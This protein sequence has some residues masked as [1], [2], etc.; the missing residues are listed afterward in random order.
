MRKNN[1]FQQIKIIGLLIFFFAACGGE[2]PTSPQANNKMKTE[3]IATQVPSFNMDS[4]FFFV[5]KQTTFGPRV[6]NSEAHKECGNWLQS[7][8]ERFADTVYVQNTRV[9]AYDGT[10]LE[11]RNIIGSFHPEVR[12]RIMLSAHWDTRPWA[13]RDPDPANHYKPYDGANDGASGVGVLLEIARLLNQHSPAIGIDIVFFDAEDYG[14]HEQAKNFEPDSWALG[15]Q[16][17]AKS[18][19]KP[20]YF[21]RFGILLDMV[22]AADATFKQEGYSLLFAPNIVRNVWDTAQQLGFGQYFINTEGGH[23][24]DDHYYINDI[25]NIPTINIID[26]RIDTPHGFFEHWHTMKDNMDAIDKNT[27]HAVGTTV[28]HIIYQE[29]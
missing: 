26:Q 4:A 29:Q 21:A 13:D 16:H 20:D 28:L 15:S 25:R 19:H 9:R 7:T 14:Q 6:P 10:V 3:T 17:W 27:L 24:M 5:K 11:I 22:G 8:M 2:R 18:P 1:H 12:K 23:I